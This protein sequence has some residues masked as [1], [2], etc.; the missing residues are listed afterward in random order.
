M[1][2]KRIDRLPKPDGKDWIIIR[3][4]SGWGWVPAF[5]ELADILRAIAEIE[6]EKYKNGRGRD[7]VADWARDAIFG[8]TNDELEELYQI[9]K[10]KKH[11]P[12]P[13]KTED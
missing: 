13:Q 5:W 11:E 12:N 9:P 3:F 1:K 8:M 2:I 6:D 7:M 4:D 10:R